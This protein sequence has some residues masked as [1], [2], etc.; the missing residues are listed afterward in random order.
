MADDINYTLHSESGDPEKFKEGD[1]LSL[2]V[3]KTLRH[4]LGKLLTDS[5]NAYKPRGTFSTETR[6]EVGDQTEV[7][8]LGAGYP[9]FT[10]PIRVGGDGSIK[11]FESRG[12]KWAAHLPHQAPTYTPPFDIPPGDPFVAIT[13]KSIKSRDPG[14][15]LSLSLIHI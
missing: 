7:S 9:G 14:K 2:D 5:S 1:D 3:K 4:Y 12:W 13:D 8:A 6:A 10:P 11:P 15:V